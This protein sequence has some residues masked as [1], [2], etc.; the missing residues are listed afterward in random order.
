[1]IGREAQSQGMSDRYNHMIP[2]ID[3]SRVI[4]KLEASVNIKDRLRALYREYGLKGNHCT[5]VEMPSF[6]PLSEK[7]I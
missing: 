1:M 5:E 7:T 6:Y 4:L 3:K 2:D